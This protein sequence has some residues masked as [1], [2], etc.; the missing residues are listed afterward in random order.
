V[1]N[2]ICAFDTS[3]RAPILEPF[4]R[5]DLSRD[6][7]SVTSVA[8]ASTRDGSIIYAGVNSSEEERLKGQNAHLRAFDLTYPKRQKGNNTSD[9]NQGNIEYLSKTQLFGAAS[10]TARKEGYQRLVRLSPPGGKSG[11]KRLGVVASSLQGNENELVIFPAV[12]TKPTSSD[13]IQRIALKDKEANDV[14]ILEA[15]D[16]RFQV[17]YCLDYSVYVQRFDYNF[18]TRKTGKKLDVPS[19]TYDVPYPDGNVVLHLRRSTFADW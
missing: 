6:E 13:V 3:S 16:G 14:D 7:D 15:A 12:S 9:T 10:E 8:T 11:G 4:A 17:A 1:P 18:E 2:S 5:T 19:K